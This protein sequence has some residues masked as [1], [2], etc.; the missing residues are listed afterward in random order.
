MNEI[1]YGQG[2]VHC[3]LKHR[4]RFGIRDS[5]REKDC[6]LKACKTGC[7]VKRM[8]Q[9]ITPEELRQIEVDTMREHYKE[10]RMKDL[11]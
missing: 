9:A 5:L 11:E 2:L 10:K 6:E 4:E 7:P 8:P 1:A 3:C